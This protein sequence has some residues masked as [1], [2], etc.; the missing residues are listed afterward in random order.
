MKARHL[1]Q[2]QEHWL[3]RIIFVIFQQFT[4]VNIGHDVT[5]SELMILMS[6]GT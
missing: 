5:Y 2:A 4:G 3:L 1:F 6:L